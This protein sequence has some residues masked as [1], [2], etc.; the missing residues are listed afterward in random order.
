MSETVEKK[1][2]HV[3]WSVPKLTNHAYL[4]DAV[5]TDKKA[6]FDLQTEIN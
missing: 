3:P 5:G 4:R 1:F 6:A 2:I